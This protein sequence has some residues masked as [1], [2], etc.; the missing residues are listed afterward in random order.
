MRLTRNGL[1]IYHRFLTLQAAVKK[2]FQFSLPFTNE[3]GK[4]IKQPVTPFPAQR[5]HNIT[6]FFYFASTEK[7]F[8][9]CFLTFSM[10]YNKN[11]R[12][13][14]E[15]EVQDRTNRANRTDRTD[16]GYRRFAP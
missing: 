15:R 5:E 10:G 12:T 4:S 9:G 2:I 3:P 16:G 13:A 8:F 6:S 14:G 7:N 1:L 11:R